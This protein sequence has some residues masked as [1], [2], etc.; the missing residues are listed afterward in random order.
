MQV[1][2]WVGYKL[3]FSK[4]AKKFLSHLSKSDVRAIRCKTQAIVEGV[5][6]LDILKLEGSYEKPT[7]RLRVGNFRVI[8]EVHNK[9]ITIYVVEI[10]ARKNIYE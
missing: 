6:N 2:H 5:L 1:N 10:G 7:Y 3:I 9:T 8:F 4:T